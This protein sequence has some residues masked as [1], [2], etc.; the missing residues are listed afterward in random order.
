M[1][2]KCVGTQF[3]NEKMFCSRCL[4]AQS[5]AMME[6]LSLCGTAMMERLRT[7][8]DLL[9]ADLLSPHKMLARALLEY[10][11]LSYVAVQPVS[12]KTCK[13]MK[14]C[15]WAEL[16]SSLKREKRHLQS[17][18]CLKTCTYEAFLSYLTRIFRARKRE[19]TQD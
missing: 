15:T 19:S 4:L 9:G 12:P 1:E 7:T 6:S 11:L 8:F 17:S 10:T 5:L 18:P 2:W 14:I 13:Q 16:H 3:Q